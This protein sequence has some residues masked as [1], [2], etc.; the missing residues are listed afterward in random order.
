MKRHLRPRYLGPG[1]VLTARAVFWLLLGLFTAT[2]AVPSRDLDSRLL[3]QTA[4]SLSIGEGGELS[5]D[6]AGAAR[7]LDSLD[8]LRFEGKLAQRAG[9]GLVWTREPGNAMTAVPFLVAGEWIGRAFPALEER[10]ARLSAGVEFERLHF[11]EGGLQPGLFAELLIGWRDVLLACAT[12]YLAAL[13]ILR[14]GRTRRQAFWV[15]LGLG[16]SS[17]LW[18]EARQAGAQVQAAFLLVLSVYALIAVRERFLRFERPPFGLL[19]VLGAA[20]AGLVLTRLDL[21]LCGLGLLG[22]GVQVV[23]RGRRRLWS[24]PL[25]KA[26]AGTSGALRDLAWLGLPLVLAVVGAAWIE[27]GLGAL[28]ERTVGESLAPLNPGPSLERLRR[29]ALLLVSPGLGLIWFGPLVLLAPI[30]LWRHRHDRLLVFSVMWCLF[31]VLLA[32]VGR[33]DWHGSVAFGPRLLLPVV[34]LLWIACALAFDSRRKL[35]FARRIALALGLFGLLATLGGV[36]VDRGTYVELGYQALAGRSLPAPEAAAS[37]GGSA[38]PADT[39]PGLG[40]PDSPGSSRTEPKELALEPAEAL[41]REQWNWGFAQPWAHWRILRHR[42]ALPDMAFRARQVFFEPGDVMLR[43]AL[44][45]ER[46]FQHFAWVYLE[47]PLN[48]IAWPVL[49]GCFL[50][51]ALGGIQATQGLD[52]TRP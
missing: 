17:F 26:R 45:R 34:P 48:G 46:D 35:R 31:A 12:C 39:V 49:L 44:D 4:H 37:T 13:G 14:L 5:L 11:V 47:E 30:G 16:V 3:T 8:Q 40:A 15:A 10:Y 18:V 43:P 6:Q 19:L 22:A 52:P 24:S 33:E 28:A 9:R 38:K 25:M 29:A 50:L 41:A 1:D 23:A 36:A 51:F 21:A 2:L 20:L 27:G 42:V 32:C 7:V